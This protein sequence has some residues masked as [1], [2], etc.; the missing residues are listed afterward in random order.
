MKVSHTQAVVRISVAGLALG[1]VVAGCSK[2]DSS[3]A[4][5]SE[6]SS[7]SSSAA[8]SSEESSA[9]EA[10]TSAAAPD[11]TADYS[12]LLIKPDVIP[13]GAGDFV[14]EAP[15]LN[16][17]GIPGAAQLLHNADNTANIGDT[18]LLTDTPEKAAAALE[19]SKKSLP[20]SVTGTPAPLPS[21]GPDATIAAGTSPD[22]SK[23]VT[24]LLFT[25]D[26]SIVSL[27]FDSAPGDL[28]PV[29]TDFVEAVGKA[30]Q[31]AV[32]AGL[33]NIGK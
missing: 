8:S 12:S 7:A 28:N 23:A 6:S 25:V 1:L 17:N 22:G 21:I 24:V 9:T 30:Q 13:P 26:N 20:S 27:E 32:T 33:P 10:P 14:A 11:P 18:V 16:P 15:Q 5:S 4:S 31:D 3:S 2:G 19:N 29:P